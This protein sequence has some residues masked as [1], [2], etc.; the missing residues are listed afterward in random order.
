MPAH[1]RTAPCPAHTIQHASLS[2]PVPS[3]S[4]CSC[5]A[6]IVLRV[7]THTR[8]PSSSCITCCTSPLVN[9]TC[10]RPPH[11]A[12][13]HTHGSSAL[14]LQRSVGKHVFIPL[15]P[16]PVT[17][18]KVYVLAELAGGL[19]AGLCSWPLYGTG[20]SWKN[21]FGWVTHLRQVGRSDVHGCA[22][23]AKCWC[24]W[25]CL[26]P[27]TGAGWLRTYMRA[28]CTGG[29]MVRGSGPGAHVHL[30]MEPLLLVLPDRWHM[31]RLGP[32]PPPPA[33]APATAPSS[34][35]NRQQC[36]PVKRCFGLL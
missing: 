15:R 16:T 28:I 20:P 8:A 22:W 4:P 34:V 21:F 31:R 2:R 10:A 35:P 24:G 12:E 7:S 32:P 18:L 6:F 29:G 19:L 5:A 26:P 17:G 3:Q 30:L 33:L 14:W 13:H 1:A 9:P 36:K 11:S 23:P 27:A 25:G